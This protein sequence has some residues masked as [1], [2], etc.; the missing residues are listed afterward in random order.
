[1]DLDVACG[2][3]SGIIVSETINIQGTFR[4][5]D[6]AGKSKFASK[7]YCKRSKMPLFVSNDVQF[8]VIINYA[9]GDKFKI[10]YRSVTRSVGTKIPRT[11]PKLT[12]KAPTITQMGSWEAG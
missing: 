3:K 12:T 8:E 1:M 6:V 5:G 11:K 9:P 4:S 7:R 10:G 2:G